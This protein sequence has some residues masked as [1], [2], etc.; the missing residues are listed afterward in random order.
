MRS[1]GALELSS[2]VF[3][4]INYMPLLTSNGQLPAPYTLRVTLVG[5][6]TAT[7]PMWVPA[8]FTTSATLSP[9]C[10]WRSDRLADLAFNGTFLVRNYH[11]QFLTAR[12]G[13]GL[14]WVGARLSYSFAPDGRPSVMAELPRP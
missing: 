6:F 3:N 10:Q 8:N 2:S 13:N 5:Q 7:S 12:T 14:V 11:G 9:F 4:L 1:Y